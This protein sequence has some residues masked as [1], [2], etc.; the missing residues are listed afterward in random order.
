MLSQTPRAFAVQLNGFYLEH[1]YKQSESATL[2]SEPYL[3]HYDHSNHPGRP[4]PSS[5][6][7]A[8]LHHIVALCFE[9]SP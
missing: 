6:H 4:N 8:R 3:S 9:F 1:R 7:K 2:E 5:S